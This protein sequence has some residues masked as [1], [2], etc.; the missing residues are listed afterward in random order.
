MYWIL[1]HNTKHIAS[2]DKQQKYA[3]LFPHTSPLSY[4][5]SGWPGT[6]P[7]D[8][9]EKQPGRKTTGGWWY[10]CLPV[11]QIQFTKNVGLERYHSQTDH[12]SWLTQAVEE[13]T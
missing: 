2:N 5:R 9:L 3:T 13:I 10:D 8:Q 4:D 11:M 12:V 1:Q 7:P 6:T